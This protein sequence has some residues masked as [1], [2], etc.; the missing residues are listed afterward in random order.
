[1][2]NDGL[3]EFLLMSILNS[4]D[5]V[6]DSL[7]KTSIPSGEYGSP[8]QIKFKEFYNRTSITLNAESNTQITHF[9]S[10]ITPRKTGN[11]ILIGCQWCGEV[12][13]LWNKMFWI[14]R[15]GYGGFETGQS[16]STTLANTTQI[17]TQCGFDTYEAGAENNATTGAST[18]MWVLD[19][20]ISTTS[21]V[22]YSLN[23]SCDTSDVLYTNRTIEDADLAARE[24]FRSW[25]VLMELSGG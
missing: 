9:Q 15:T 3:G 7:S 22:T 5:L 12:D 1:M 2:Y 8:I 13:D 4:A 25:M 21:T 20:A 16:N 18:T 23:V 11:K 6:T 17:G 24:R 10:T 14:G 19:T